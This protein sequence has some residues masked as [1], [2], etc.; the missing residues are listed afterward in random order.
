MNFTAFDGRTWLEG[1][2]SSSVV[3][4][5]WLPFG[6]WFEFLLFEWPPE[7]DWWLD[8]KNGWLKNSL[9]DMRSLVFGRNNP[10]KRIWNFGDVPDGILQ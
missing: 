6:C 4:I 3:S 5:Q 2:A 10:I 1:L 9:N 8:F 7:A